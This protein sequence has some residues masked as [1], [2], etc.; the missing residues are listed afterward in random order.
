MSIWNGGTVS[1][2]ETTTT[3]IGSTSGLDLQVIISA[4]QAQLVAITDS[5]SPNIYKVKTI[6]KAI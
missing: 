2:T 1:Y 5:T 6:I 3:D 4:S